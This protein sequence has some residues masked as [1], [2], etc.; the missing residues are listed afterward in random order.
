[1][2]YYPIGLDIVDKKCIV[3]GGGDVA[4]RKAIKLLDYGARVGVVSRDLTPCLRDMAKEGTI[5]HIDSDYQKEH[6]SGAFLVIGA[7]NR[8]VVNTQLSIDA[9]EQGILINAVDNPPECDFILPALLE[10]GD[11]V[12]A[13]FTGGNSPALAK[14]LRI[15]LEDHFGPEY[16]IFL[17]IMGEVRQKVLAKGLPSEENKRI[18]ELIIDSDMPKLIKYKRWDVIRNFLKRT[19]GEDIEVSD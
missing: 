1:M 16:E 3:V 10:R 6:I 15:Q 19:T 8:P 9:R 18:F 17:N 7:T 14:K 13:V 5:V 11:L 2:K 4:E 12:I